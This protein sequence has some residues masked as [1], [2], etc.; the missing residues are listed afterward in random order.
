MK[1]EGKVAFVTG[2]ANGIGREAAKRFKETGAKVILSDIDVEKGALLAKELDSYFIKLDVSSY[3]E[4]QSAF[5]VANEVHGKLDIVFLNA[6]V[7]S[8]IGIDSTFNAARYREVMGINLDGVVYGLNSALPYLSS[9]GGQ[10][11][12]TASMAGIVALPQDPI[13]SANKHGVVGLIRSVGEGVAQN[14]KVNAI[15]PSFA[16]TNIIKDVKAVLEELKFPILKV[17]EVIDTL[18]EILDSNERGK[19]WFVIPGRKSEPFSF[20]N[21]PGPRV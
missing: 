20:R 4:N 12:A 8:N 6:G 2:A 19:C 7:S 16:D 11:V 21:A 10:I 5:K 3:D 14:I 13:Y 9:N 1:Y 18:F 15:C 17:S